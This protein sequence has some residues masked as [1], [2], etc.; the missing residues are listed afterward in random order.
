[1]S[2][3]IQAEGVGKEYRIGRNGARLDSLRERLTEVFMAPFRRMRALAS[4]H[5]ATTADERFWALRN[6]CFTVEPGEVVGVVGRNGAGKST[7]LKILSRIT[8][9]TEGR[10]IIRGR[11]GSL[12]EVGTGFH[13][14]MTG[15]DN[16]FMNAAILGM[17]RREVERKLDEIVGFAEVER[18]I[19]TPVKHYSSGM[20]LR[21]AFAVAAHLETDILLVDEVLAVGDAVFQRKCLGRM[22]DVARGGRTVLFVSHNMSAIQELCGRCLWLEGGSLVADGSPAD[23]VARYLEAGRDQVRPRYRGQASE[24]GRRTSLLAA[25]VLGANGEPVEELR[26]GEPFGIRMAW[27]NAATIPGVLFVVNVTDSLGRL[28]FAV[29]TRG[30]SFE[31]G[32]RGLHSFTCWFSENVLIP[33]E[34]HVTLVAVVMPRDVVQMVEDCLALVVTPVAYRANTFYRRWHRPVLIAPQPT[35]SADEPALALLR[36]N[37]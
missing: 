24:E 27:D 14:E 17:R 18:F 8:E 25:D 19:N 7:L 30:A 15:R 23:V 35:W 26:F 12:L 36:D 22:S 11:V 13:P 3:A 5:A 28:L 37:G 6:V 29:D 20:Y 16:I 10:A 32:S 31:V 34:Y 21:L 4:G 33:G 9:P 1:M 2:T